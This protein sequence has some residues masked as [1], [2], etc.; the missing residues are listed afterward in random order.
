[1]NHVIFRR[2]SVEFFPFFLMIF[3]GVF[4]PC[5][6]LAFFDILFK[7][8]NNHSGSKIIRPSLEANMSEKG[9]EGG[10]R[11]RRS[12]RGRGDTKHKE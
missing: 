3:R 2:F 5:K 8:F 12:S 6:T 7:Q 11:K 1:M 9:D 10:R 4:L